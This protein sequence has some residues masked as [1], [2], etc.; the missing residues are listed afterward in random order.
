MTDE[1][2]A[3][4]LEAERAWREVDL[5]ARERDRYRNANTKHVRHDYG[6]DST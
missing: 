4:R 6:L 3:L 1:Q 2:E 5:I